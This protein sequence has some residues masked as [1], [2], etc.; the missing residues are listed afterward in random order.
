MTNSNI[1]RQKNIEID[2]SL[3]IRPEDLGRDETVSEGFFCTADLREI[4]DRIS[5][6]EEALL[7]SPDQSGGSASDAAHFP[8][9]LHPVGVPLLYAK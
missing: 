8:E 1:L 2:S 9:A 4:L 3:V 6:Q 5:E 7:N